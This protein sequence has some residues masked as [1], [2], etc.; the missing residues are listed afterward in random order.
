M[1]FSRTYVDQRAH[2]VSYMA[3]NAYY[4]KDI[5]KKFNSQFAGPSSYNHELD[6]ERKL[7][8]MYAM[9]GSMKDFRIESELNEACG[10]PPDSR[11]LRVTND[12][13]HLYTDNFVLRHYDIHNREYDETIYNSKSTTINGE[14]YN[15][16]AKPFTMPGK[17]LLPNPSYNSVAEN[18]LND[19]NTQY[20][21]TPPIIR[22][23]PF[24]S[25]GNPEY[26]YSYNLQNRIFS[27]M[28]THTNP[29]LFKRGLLFFIGDYAYTGLRIIPFQGFSYFVILIGDDCKEGMTY[30]FFESLWEIDTEWKLLLLPQDYCYWH[31]GPIDEMCNEDGLLLST[32][33]ENEHFGR[34]RFSTKYFVLLTTPDEC[35][36]TVDTITPG[37]KEDP[38]SDIEP[39]PV[40]TYKPTSISF[41]DTFFTT[42]NT[43]TNAFWLN[44]NRSGK[45]YAS[46]GSTNVRAC[47]IALKYYSKDVD[48]DTIPEQIQLYYAENGKATKY[49]YISP[50]ECTI[51]L[52]S[53][54]DSELTKV[55]I[56][57]S[58]NVSLYYPDVYVLTGEELES[59]SDPCRT[60]VLFHARYSFDPVTMVRTPRIPR[61]K[62]FI[63]DYVN[64]LNTKEGYANAIVSGNIAKS[65]DKYTPAPHVYSMDDFHNSLGLTSTR[66]E[67]ELLQFGRLISSD[68]SIMPHYFE[69]M[70]EDIIDD[71]FEFDFS[72]DDM[73]DTNTY[74]NN[75]PFFDWIRNW[76][77]FPEPM[78]HFV[79]SRSGALTAKISLFIN[80][81]IMS[82]VVYDFKSF[83]WHVFFPAR[84]ANPGTKIHVIY[85]ENKSESIEPDIYR[86]NDPDADTEFRGH[87]Y[88]Y[89]IKSKEKNSD[90]TPNGI[91]LYVN[92]TYHQK[93][94][95][96]YFTSSDEDKSMITDLP[97]DFNSVAATDMVVYVKDKTSPINGKIFDLASG[98]T[99]VDV[100]A[101]IRII[102]SELEE[103]S[104]DDIPNEVVMTKSFK[105]W[106]K[107]YHS[108]VTIQSV[109]LDDSHPDILQRDTVMNNDV[110]FE[111]IFSSVIIDKTRNL[112]L[113][114]WYEESG[115]NLHD[116]IGSHPGYKVFDKPMRY[117]VI[118]GRE[119]EISMPSKVYLD[120]VDITND[121][122]R[123]YA[124]L[125]NKPMMYCFFPDGLAQKGSVF[126]IDTLIA[127]P[128]SPNKQYEF[129]NTPSIRLD[130]T[131]ND[132]LKNV[133]LA[134]QPTNIYDWTI[135]EVGPYK[136]TI[137]WP[138]FKYGNP[139]NESIRIWDMS[140]TESENP[141]TDLTLNEVGDPVPMA[142]KYM[143]LGKLYIKERTIKKLEKYEGTL[144]IEIE[145]ESRPRVFLVEHLP[146]RKKMTIAK[147]G[148]IIDMNGISDSTL[149]E[150]YLGGVR[151]DGI[152]NKN[153]GKLSQ[154]KYMYPIDNSEFSERDDVVIL[155]DHI[156]TDDDNDMKE[157]SWNNVN[158]DLLDKIA[159]ED[160]DF[161]NYLYQ[162]SLKR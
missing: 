23:F 68:T 74:T 87:S 113:L 75:K 129:E 46:F 67:Y 59:E 120:G 53:S 114:E 119:N 122:F 70:K 27:M 116:L 128:R 159:N 88:P 73:I 96:G 149:R 94:R 13:L 15:M 118:R 52:K 31:E 86:F 56:D 7:C 103:A 2:G 76:L 80:G 85:Y 66:D 100:Y 38:T 148:E 45:I 124:P 18:F 32:F 117:F 136:H 49:E 104:I 158:F 143:G 89:Y 90:G 125:Q 51:V 43:S 21:E 72:V 36:M 135:C 16:G 106:Y 82:N 30:D 11:S 63:T 142:D 97:I 41:M 77:D 99:E 127:D 57:A 42:Y 138:N 109:T 4:N 92:T 152:H 58:T 28:D 22:H 84:Y 37:I 78:R 35:N 48:I 54:D 126:N 79:I 121:V 140:F 115:L 160:K 162:V 60:L 14:I 93:I 47:V 101:P 132:E 55:S 161:Q 5:L 20:L 144:E 145:V 10:F 62:N 153:Y 151:L 157:M 137:T 156:F 40:I 33:T 3:D 81:Q 154:N 123:C 44:A 65:F 150:V 29:D 133:D 146:Y 19:T 6:E 64:Y 98:L 71:I 112:N 24:D 50:P 83:V 9:H 8:D 134:I 141:N 91:E 26:E 17:R 34:N 155:S 102:P 107:P 131:R 105:K 111:S 95:Y 69:K 39:D 12:F 25:D 110:V 147:A 108:R 61:F 130:V 1:D 139:D